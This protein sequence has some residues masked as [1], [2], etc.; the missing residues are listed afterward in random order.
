MS[1]LR[2]RAY[3]AIK[4]KSKS[5]HTIELLG[6][7]VEELKIHLEKQFVKDMNWQNYGQWHIDHIKPCSSFDLTDPEQQK[8]CFHYSN[9][10]P[11]WAKDN[12]KKSNKY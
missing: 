6:C 5:K 9:L 3:S 1:N 12:I 8:L 4:G 11:L 10:Q 2:S 7:S